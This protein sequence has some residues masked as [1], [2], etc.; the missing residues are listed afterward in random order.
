MKKKVLHDLTPAYKINPR[1]SYLEFD[2][3]RII[4]NKKGRY[5]IQNEN[6]QFPDKCYTHVEM[7]QVMK[8]VGYVNN[9]KNVCVAFR[10]NGID[11]TF[12]C[13]TTRTE[14]IIGV[15]SFERRFS[16]TTVRNI[17]D[18][19][20]YVTEDNGEYYFCTGNHEEARKP[21]EE[22]RYCKC[23]ECGNYMCVNCVGYYCEI[24]EWDCY[25]LPISNP[26]V[27]T[28]SKRFE[29]KGKSLYI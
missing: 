8:V 1:I 24:C 25:H 28:S 2:G 10:L 29:K 12:F 17:K 18:L 16:L 21:D 4:K 9:G 11:C 5:I 7:T 20:G 27:Y 26:Y 19:K 6:P 3:L 13:H 22:S 23:F 15:V 14:Y